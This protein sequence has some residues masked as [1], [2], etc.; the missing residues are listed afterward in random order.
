MLKTGILG[1]LLLVLVFLL[2]LRHSLANWRR[3][4]DP[5][6]RAIV[7]A[8]A[9]TVIGLLPATI[10]NPIFSENY[11]TPLLGIMMGIN[12]VLYRLHTGPLEDTPV[13]T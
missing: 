7:L 13:T 11:W 8:F 1:Y 6:L 5:Y 3:V 2:F 4:R 9:V 10:V 12:E